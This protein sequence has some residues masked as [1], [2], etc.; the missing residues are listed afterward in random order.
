MTRRDLVR[1]MVLNEICDDFEHVD[2]IIFPHVRDL[3]SKRGLTVER[4]EVI[5]ALTGLVQDGLAKAYE[6]SPAAESP[7][8]GELPGMPSDVDSESS[9]YFYITPAGMDVHLADDWW[10]FDDEG[11]LLPGWTPQP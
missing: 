3:A 5:D 7:F 11:A 6:L 9:M 2:H 1:L 8:H 4:T 10:P